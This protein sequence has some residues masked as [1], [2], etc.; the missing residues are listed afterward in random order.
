MSGFAAWVSGHRARRVVFIAGLFPLPFTG[1]ISAA[2]VVLS[3]ELKGTREAAIDCL[4]AMALLT[5]MLALSGGVEA[6]LLLLFAGSSWG[7]ALGLGAIAGRYQ[8]LTFAVQVAVMV[9][10]AGLLLSMVLVEDVT[11]YWADI[12]APVV[13]DINEQGLAE[14]DTAALQ[15]IAEIMPGVV[16]FSVLA[17]TV[18]S[19]LLGTWWFARLKNK[20]FAGMFRQIRMGYVIGV[21]AA[22]AGIA[23]LLGV[24]PVADNLLW[25][26][27]AGFVL[28]GLSVLYWHAW[29][30]RWPRA[31]WIA[32][33]V[34][35]LLSSALLTME[36]ALLAVIGFVDNWYNLRP[37]RQDMV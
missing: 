35:P 36:L 18:A 5:A 14:I 21:L 6:L 12:I 16:A 19:L 31:W 34:L 8:S 28:H 32:V 3:A 26:F 2:L 25:F 10:L 30:R 29:R 37:E 9:V 22:L 20:D 17:S 13:D 24:Q 4:A 7:V 1:L 33:Y 15:A 23:A 27:A 11:A